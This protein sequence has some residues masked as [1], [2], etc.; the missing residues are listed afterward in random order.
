MSEEDT[1]EQESQE[2]LIVRMK[3]DA[4]IRPIIEKARANGWRV[5]SARGSVELCRA[6]WI[7]GTMSGIEVRGYAPTVADNELITTLKKQYKSSGAFV[8]R[9]DEV[10]E[11][12][13]RRVIPQLEQ[14]YEMLRQKRAKLGITTTDLDR[15]Y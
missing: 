4:S 8:M 10:V 12:Y 14:E 15:T 13:C 7:E 9:A 1:T 6:V 2:R 5:I 11:D 3:N